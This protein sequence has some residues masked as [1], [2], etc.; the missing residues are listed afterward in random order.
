MSI[1]TFICYL[2]GLLFHIFAGLTK[3]T[4]KTTFGDCNLED[5]FFTGYLIAQIRKCSNVSVRNIF[6]LF[7]NV[8]SKM[9]VDCKSYGMPFHSWST[10]S[11]AV[12]TVTRLRGMTSWRVL[13]DHRCRRPASDVIMQCSVT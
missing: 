2:T 3:Q 7:F 9:S 1:I 12:V 13:A 10:D 5:R 8:S 4:A 6:S 11:E